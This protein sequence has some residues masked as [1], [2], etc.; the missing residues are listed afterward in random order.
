M[1][2]YYYSYGESVYRL[3]A[4]CEGKKYNSE[5]EELYR[6]KIAVCETTEI[7]SSSDVVD[8]VIAGSTISSLRK[9][10]SIIDEYG[11][12]LEMPKIK[13][14][15]YPTVFGA[16]PFLRGTDGKLYNRYG[17]EIDESAIIFGEDVHKRI[18]KNG[19]MLKL[20]DENNLPYVVPKFRLTEL[21]TKF[22]NESDARRAGF[23][24]VND[25][26]SD[27]VEVEAERF[28]LTPNYSVCLFEWNGLIYS[29]Q[30]HVLQHRM[31]CNAHLYCDVAYCEEYNFDE[32]EQLIDKKIYL[33]RK[34]HIVF[35]D[36]WNGDRTSQNYTGDY[37]PMVVKAKKWENVA[38]CQPVKMFDGKKHLFA[39]TKDGRILNTFDSDLGAGLTNVEHAIVTGNWA[40]IA[41]K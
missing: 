26:F 30:K 32:I 36:G 16:Y 18:R 33:D 22:M 8:I 9:D 3:I 40:L 12:V 39:K 4:V 13:K 25:I 34:G 19:K 21:D 1:K 31:G 15:V 7:Q 11:N 24:Y 41:T 23:A 29:L 6:E 28:L 38:Y 2:F 5:L 20:V 14:A 35:L 27:S 10:G 37:S 17:K